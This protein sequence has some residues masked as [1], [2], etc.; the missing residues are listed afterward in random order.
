M[1]DYELERGYFEWLYD[2]VCSDGYV[3]KLDYH[4]LLFHLHHMDFVYLLPRDNNRFS[5]GVNLR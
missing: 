2:L 4:E 1:R 5:D 3:E